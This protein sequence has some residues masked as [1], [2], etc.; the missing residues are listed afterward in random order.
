MAIDGLVKSASEFVKDTSEFSKSTVDLDAR[1]K[2]RVAISEAEKAMTTDRSSNTINLDRRLPHSKSNETTIRPE[3]KTEI[4]N[5]LSS[6]QKNDLTQKGVSPG[7]LDKISYSDGVY[8]IKTDNNR[9]AEGI[10]PD[11]KVPYKT[12]IVD[13]LGVKIEGVFPDFKPVFDTQLPEGL[14]IAKDKAQFEY[15]TEQL[16]NAVNINPELRKQFSERQLAQ[17]EKGITP[18]GFVWH[19]N[20]HRGRMELVDFNTHESSHHTGGKAIWG[21][22]SKER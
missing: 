4:S 5:S 2:S 8:K 1:I 14:I 12:K 9:L 17:I 3:L 13:V 11:T 16:R 21:G 20:E 7:M 18:S 6:E 22:G 15:C 10:H 19:H